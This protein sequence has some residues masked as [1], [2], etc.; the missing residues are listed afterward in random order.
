MPSGHWQ[1]FERW[2]LSMA[3]V[4]S[5]IYAIVVLW[6]A[7]TASDL[8]LRVLLTDP[9]PTA[10]GVEIRA[11]LEDCVGLSFSPQS[12]DRL[13]AIARTPV[14]SFRD[15]TAALAD[16]RSAPREPEIEVQ[17][18]GDLM[19]TMGDLLP[20][21][22]R[23]AGRRWV[24]VEIDRRVS[25]G[26]IERHKTRLLAH[27][28]PPFDLGL[29]IVWFAL[30]LGIFA[31]AALSH[32]K[33]PFDRGARL[34]FAM[35]AVTTGAFVGGFHWWLIASSVWLSVPLVVCGVLLP[36]VTLHFFLV[37]PEPK[38]YLAPDT[39][40]GALLLYGLPVAALIWLIGLT[41]STS[42]SFGPA[43]PERLRQLLAM[44][45]TGL[46]HTLCVRRCS[47]RRRWRPWSTVRRRSA[48]RCSKPKYGGLCGR[49]WGRRSRWGT[50]CTW[51]ASTKRRSRWA[52][53]RSR[54]SPRASCL[55][56]RMRWE[57]R[58]TS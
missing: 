2:F 56:W 3:G 20:P 52:R 15:F 13:V 30:Q 31:L 57:S 53:R 34:F 1:R 7:A 17:A 23:R 22:V 38:R 43:E 21:V 4:V 8:R 49:R 6:V 35:C 39:A 27:A 19:A 36:V 40:R 50:R 14:H 55:C 54:C 28:L 24:E 5:V 46:R 32:W 9:N 25:S 37:Y 26:E 48:T 18:S 51:R 45:E 29:S 12:G 33:R 58:G 10:D 16:L 44:L 42:P 41:M 11:V 47:S